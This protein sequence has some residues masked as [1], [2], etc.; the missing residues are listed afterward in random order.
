MDKG[1]KERRGKG[2][3]EL[4]KAGKAP[5]TAIH[6]EE[7]ENKDAEK[8]IGQDETSV[9]KKILARDGRKLSVKAEP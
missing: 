1:R 5:H 8:G 4:D 9:G 3:L 7:G 2:A 6:A